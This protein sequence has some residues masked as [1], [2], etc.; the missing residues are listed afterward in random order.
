M[1]SFLAVESPP[2]IIKANPSGGTNSFTRSESKESQRI[3]KVNLTNATAESLGEPPKG[4]FHF[5][6]MDEATGIYP[7]GA[8]CRDGVYCI[9]D[10][11]LFFKPPKDDWHTVI[12][13]VNIVKTFGGRMPRLPVAYVGKGRFAVAKTTK[14]HVEVPKEKEKDFDGT[15]GLSVTMLLDGRTGKVLKE[16]KPLLYDNN[17]SLKIPDDWWSPDAKPPT[18]K[19]QTAKP[20]CFQ[21]NDAGRTVRFARNKQITLAENEEAVESGDG[22]YLAIAGASRGKKAP[23]K[24]ILRIVD[25]RIGTVTECPI[26]ADSKNISV[27]AAWQVLCSEQPDKATLDD[28]RSSGFDY[29]LEPM[30]NW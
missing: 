5:F 10:F 22:R 24:T 17:P 20:S 11:C 27:T 19:K 2:A 6:S 28:F 4:G 16:T 13:N 7:A 18:P 9:R 14:D 15:P 29:F 21:Q 26:T 12:E 23:S 1:R 8:D 30:A 3:V 25:G